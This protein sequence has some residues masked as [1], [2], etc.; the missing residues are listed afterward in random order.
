[1]LTPAPT[2]LTPAPPANDDHN[3]DAEE[4]EMYRQHKAM[5]MDLNARKC[6]SWQSGVGGFDVLEEY[7]AYLQ[8]SMNQHLQ[9]CKDV[10]TLNN[11]LE[12]KQEEYKKLWMPALDKFFNEKHDKI[13]RL[14]YRTGTRTLRKFKYLEIIYIQKELKRKI[15]ALVA[16]TERLNEEYTTTLNAYRNGMCGCFAFVLYSAIYYLHVV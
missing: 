8:Q 10:R 15:N 12:T 11:T 14:I 7:S 16:S 3:D 2:V 1:V 13:G 9:Y 4:D 6:D 5:Y